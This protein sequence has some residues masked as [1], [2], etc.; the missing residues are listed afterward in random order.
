MNCVNFFVTLINIT[1]K[2]DSYIDRL[3]WLNRILFCIVNSQVEQTQEILRHVCL[4][5]QFLFNCFRCLFAVCI[6]IRILFCN[7][8][9][10]EFC[11]IRDIAAGTI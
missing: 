8:L 6:V 5:I 7:G 2:V 9:R 4:I 3:L 10:D 1:S 11:I